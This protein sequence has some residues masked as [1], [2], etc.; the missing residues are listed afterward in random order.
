MKVYMGI[1]FW[2]VFCI[3]VYNFFY[4]PHVLKVKRNVFIFLIVIKFIKLIKK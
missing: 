2:I 1:V 3:W 4:T